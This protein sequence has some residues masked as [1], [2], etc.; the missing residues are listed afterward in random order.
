MGP[1]KEERRRGLEPR[2]GAARDLEPRSKRQ[3]TS[4]KKESEERKKDWVR[5]ANND[6]DKTKEK[7]KRSKQSKQSKSGEKKNNQPD[8]NG[9]NLPCD[10]RQPLNAAADP[11]NPPLSIFEAADVVEN[12]KVCFGESV[13]ARN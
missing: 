1:S 7:T 4:N 10:G 6:D 8:R 9:G 2:N 5:S 11:A 12:R 13:G 3:P